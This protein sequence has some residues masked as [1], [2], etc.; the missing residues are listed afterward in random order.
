VSGPR[1]SWHR[2]WKDGWIGAPDSPAR[3]RSATID[4]LI[5][6]HGALRRV[7]S[8]MHRIDDGVW[9][10]NQPDPARIRRLAADGFRT[11]LNLRGETE[12][13]SY[14]LEREACRAAGLALIDLKLTSRKPPF[15]E[16][17]VALNEVF[18]TA[19][20]KMLIHCKSGA[21]RA[22]FAAALYLIL[23]KDAPVETALE[24]LSWRRLHVAGAQTG[25][26][27]FMLRR[28][29]VETA[30]APMPFLEWVTTRYDRDALRADY[31]SGP[32]SDFLVD[33]VLRRE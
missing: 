2:R 11:I 4:S 32:K 31:A 26:M 19:E 10:S 12:W 5:F 3:R 17:I 20:R 6:D 23:R 13:G 24:Q 7:W 1:R 28:Y 16:E 22:G 14:L 15:V 33:K 21:D 18:A 25:I 30:E 29:A 8:N 9:R 27:A